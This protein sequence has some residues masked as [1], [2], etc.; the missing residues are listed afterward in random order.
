MPKNLRPD[1]PQNF[2]GEWSGAD[3]D[4]PVLSWTLD[5]SV[6]NYK[7]LRWDPTIP[8]PV[9]IDDVTIISVGSV[10]TY[11]DTNIVRSEMASGSSVAY[12]L[13][14]ENSVGDDGVVSDPIIFHADGTVE[15]VTTAGPFIIGQS[16]IGGNDVLS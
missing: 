11:T 5:P 14:P 15:P 6:A 2:T 10:A 4:N 8:A 13:V 3:P 16:V 12:Q 9:P 1:K 7:L